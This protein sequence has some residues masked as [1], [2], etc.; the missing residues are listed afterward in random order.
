MSDLVLAKSEIQLALRGL[1]T[2]LSSLS[3]D[4]IPVAIDFLRQMEKTVAYNEGLLKARAL[5]FMQ[6]AGNQITEKGTLEAQVGSYT[7]RAVPT[8]TGF[9]PK[10][11]GPMLRTKRMDQEAGMDP[12]ITYKVNPDKLARL[13]SDGLLTDADLDQ[14]R[15]EKSF[16]L[17]VTRD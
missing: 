3:E 15:F 14:C 11:I 2:A 6:T 5:E 1:A 17:E 7:M 13:L 9:D 12:T 10:L 8:R 16:R 4:Q